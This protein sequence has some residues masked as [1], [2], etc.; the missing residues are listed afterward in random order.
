MNS[1]SWGT[2]EVA[3]K[4]TQKEKDEDG[5]KKIEKEERKN[6]KSW[7]SRL[8]PV[9]QLKDLR[10]ILELSKKETKTKENRG[11]Q[12]EDLNEVV[13][14]TNKKKIVSWVDKTPEETIHDKT[15]ITPTTDKPFDFLHKPK[16]TED[17]DFKNGKVMSMTP[18]ETVFWEEFIKR[19]LQPLDADKKEQKRMKK[20]LAQLRAENVDD[21]VI[22]IDAL[23]LM[24]I[25]FFVLILLLQ[26]I[27]MVI[28]R[29][30]TL[31]HLIA[32]TEI[33]NPFKCGK[34]QSHE[35]IG[36][37]G[38]EK[39]DAKTLVRFCA[40]VVGEP[41]P[42]YSSDEDDEDEE[43]EDDKV[44]Q[45]LSNTIRNNAVRGVKGNI[46]GT[47]T[48]GLGMSFRETMVIGRDS[49]SNNLRSTLSSLISDRQ[50]EI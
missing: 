48:T 26:F 35:N 36:E 39:I 23:G 25:I 28:H 1:V 2:R 18:E 14:E 19:Y 38:P 47:R 5:R 30:G 50:H 37:E 10:S 20:A 41:M 31:M 7:F 11:I 6:A 40:E 3:K 17:N 29:W 49:I 27:G 46:G 34:N 16:W 21:D 13:V 33:A 42:D 15:I 8:M 45:E 43:E 32:I 12:T 24:F 22:K 44:E 4:K 9:N